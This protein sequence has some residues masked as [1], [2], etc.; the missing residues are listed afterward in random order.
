MDLHRFGSS[1]G[2]FD[3][4]LMSVAEGRLV[5]GG[6]LDPCISLRIY[7]GLAMPPERLLSVL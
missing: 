6:V 4:R 3:E 5:Q 1:P 7:M 2:V